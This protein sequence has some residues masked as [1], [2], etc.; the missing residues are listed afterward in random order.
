MEEPVKYLVIGGQI[1]ETGTEAFL[2]SQ[3]ANYD[4]DYEILDEDELPEGLSTES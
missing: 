1:C 4:E 3:A 2:V